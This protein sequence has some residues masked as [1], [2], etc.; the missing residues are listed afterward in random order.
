[1]TIPYT[2]LIGWKLQNKFYYGVRFA[3]KCHPTDLMVSYFTSSTEVENMIKEY[4]L[5]DLIEVRKQ[6]KESVTARLWEHKVLRRMKVIKSDNWLNKTDNKA[7]QPMS[8]ELNPMFG[9]I[10]ALSH[11]HGVNLS[12]HTK[13]LIGEKSKLKKGKMPDGFSEK[14]RQIVTGRIHS[15]ETKEKI[16]SALLGRE[17]T[18]E[19]K[20]N[21]KNNH[22]DCTGKNNSFFGKTHSADT[23]QK[24]REQRKNKKWVHC[25]ETKQRKLINLTEVDSYL[26]NNWIIGKGNF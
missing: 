13:Q 5:P 20:T 16:S 12:E 3:N 26:I 17:L 23:K 19:H 18:E 7:I 4:G 21:I 8:G 25:V 10:G 6:F 15:T 24:F 2:Y 1:M 11:R 22:H 14:M 9:K